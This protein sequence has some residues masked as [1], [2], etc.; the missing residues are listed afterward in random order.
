[1]LV[2]MSLIVISPSTTSKAAKLGKVRNR[3]ANS[4]VAFKTDKGRFV[5]RHIAIF[6]DGD[7]SWA[8]PPYLG[9]GIAS[10]GV[11]SEGGRPAHRNGINGEAKQTTTRSEEGI[12]ANTDKL[13]H[14]LKGTECRESRQLGIPVNR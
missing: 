12:I 11:A 6:S 2:V 8:I 13:S 14:A 10:I 7:I 1:M 9:F 3:S 5:A 4:K